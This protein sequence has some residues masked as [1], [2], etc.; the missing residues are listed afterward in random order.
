MIR[1]FNIEKSL[2]EEIDVRNEGFEEFQTP[3]D[4]SILYKDLYYPIIK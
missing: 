4:I 1:A 2:C 3:P